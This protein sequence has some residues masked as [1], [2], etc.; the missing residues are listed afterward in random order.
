MRNMVSTPQSGEEYPYHVISPLGHPVMEATADCRYPAEQELRMLD[1]G[2]TIYFYGKKLTKT[3]IRK[4][5][6]SNKRRNE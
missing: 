4:S 3:D 6:T 2:F 5:M 1:A